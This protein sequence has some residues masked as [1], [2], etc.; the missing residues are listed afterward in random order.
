MREHAIDESAV[1]GHLDEGRGYGS[2]SCAGV[3]LLRGKKGLTPIPSLQFGSPTAFAGP[4]AGE[5]SLLSVDLQTHQE[6]ILAYRWVARF[7]HPRPIDF[8]L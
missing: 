8:A 6:T 4:P 7:R 3:V 1:Q 2:V 5:G